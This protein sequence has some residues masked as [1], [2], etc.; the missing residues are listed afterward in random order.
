MNSYDIIIIGSGPGGYNTAARAASSGLRTLLCERDKLG[1]TCLNR[2]CIPTKALCRTAQVAADMKKAA[3]FGVTGCAAPA[4]DFAVAAARKDEVVSQLRQG[5]AMLLKDVDVVEGEAQ[6][7]SS[8]TIEIA[9]QQYTSPKIIVAT[10]SR[11]ARLDIP[12]ADLAVDSDFLLSASV[13]PASIVI[14]G[15]GVIGLEFASILHACGVEVTVMEFCREILPPFDADVAKRL[16]MSL[17]R[18]GI[19]IIDRK[20]V[21]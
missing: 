12:G 15:G 11:P 17:K 8:D 10:G 3:A 1:G 6:F 21:V 2:G 18:Q 20:S 9:G 16:R 13:L 19:N 5:I 7:I 4:V 14:I